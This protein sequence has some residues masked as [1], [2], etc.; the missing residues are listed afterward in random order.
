[1]GSGGAYKHFGNAADLVDYETEITSVY[2]NADFHPVE[3]WM[4]TLGGTYTMS[5]ASFGAVDM[6]LPEDFDPE[7]DLPHADY[8]YSTVNEYSDLE[9]SQI[10]LYAKGSREITENASVYLGVGYFDLADDQPYVFGDQ[11]GSVIYVTS[12]VYAQ[13]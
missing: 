11:T 10:D 1:M 2:L 12:G 6:E 3:E 8:D 13:F 4:L 9:F 5:K 7:T